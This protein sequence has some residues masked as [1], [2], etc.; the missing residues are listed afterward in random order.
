MALTCI[1]ID[2]QVPKHNPDCP[3]HGSLT[4]EDMSKL[5]SSVFPMAEEEPI[6]ERVCQTCKYWNISEKNW[7][8]YKCLPP[9]ECRQGPPTAVVTGR[10]TGDPLWPRTLPTDWC[11]SYCSYIEEW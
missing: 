5:A 11:G 4:N 8:Q 7:R 6:L 10:G 9:F 2:R 1:C 3:I